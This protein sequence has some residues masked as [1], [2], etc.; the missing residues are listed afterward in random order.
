[1]VPFPEL[2]TTAGDA[3]F[4][5]KVGVQCCIYWAWNTF[6]TSL[7]RFSYV[8]GEVIQAWHWRDRDRLDLR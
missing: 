3:D 5:G 4:N 2:G 1:M 8:V 6:A 7:E